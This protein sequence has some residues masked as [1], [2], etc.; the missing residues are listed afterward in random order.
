MENQTS[1]Q[2]A[3]AKTFPAIWT[4]ASLGRSLE[5]SPS[6]QPGRRCCLASPDSAS[7]DIGSRRGLLSQSDQL[8]STKPRETAARGGLFVG[9]GRSLR[10]ATAKIGR[11]PSPR[12]KSPSAP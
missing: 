7:R 1:L 12:R 9:G 8:C 2:L 4:A 6:H 5:A 10:P 11:G 3:L